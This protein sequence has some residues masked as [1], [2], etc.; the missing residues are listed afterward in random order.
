MN[1]FCSLLPIFISRQQQKSFQLSCVW[2]VSSKKYAESCDIINVESESNTFSA[3]EQSLYSVQKGI[4][5]VRNK[6][7][8]KWS[9][10]WKFLGCFC[11]SYHNITH[12]QSLWELWENVVHKKKLYEKARSFFRNFPLYFDAIYAPLVPR[13]S[14]GDFMTFNFFLSSSVFFFLLLPF[15][16]SFCKMRSKYHEKRRRLFVDDAK[17]S[18]SQLLHLESL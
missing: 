13:H 11:C 14:P 18:T 3:Y 2:R 12:M 7:S 5:I 6:C 15:S 9:F 10:M 1:F 4:I 17:S 16:F 8:R